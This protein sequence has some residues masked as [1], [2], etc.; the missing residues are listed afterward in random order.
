[1]S[2]ASKCIEASQQG[3]RIDNYLINICKGV[4]K[5]RIY[6]ALRKGEVRVNQKRVK[7]DYRLI[8]GDELR[9]P[10]FRQSSCVASGQ[11]KVPP[12]DLE[13]IRSSILQEND[14]YLIVCKP[15]GIPV[16]GGT[17]VKTGLI[18]ALRVLRP[19]ASFLELVHRIDRETSGCLVVAKKRAFLLQMHQLLLHRQVKKNYLALVQGHW[20][21][22]L[23]KVSLPL[24][25]N[26][27]A[28]GERLVVVTE[29]GKPATT[30]FKPLQYFPGATLVAACPLTGRTHQ[31]R[32]HAAKSG[33]PIAGDGKYGDREFNK[34]LRRKGLDRLF[35]HSSSIYCRLNDKPANYLGLC[36]PLPVELRAVLELLH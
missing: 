18:E 11:K 13:R 28:S 8:L 22:T 36:A 19:H 4:P 17:G 3:Q 10:P 7:P 15:S 16:H 20:P 26:H 14:D 25:K 30:L 2:K 21:D 31:I 34:F 12:T 32:V 27:L 33:Y 24:R 1:M 23:K 5:T 6:R 9:I 35:L 29:D